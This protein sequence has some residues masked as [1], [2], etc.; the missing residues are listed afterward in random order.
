MG[1]GEG[2]RIANRSCVE[3]DEV[4]LLAPRDP[5]AIRQPDLVGRHAGHLSDRSGEIHEPPLADKVSENARVG[6]VVARVGARLA[7]RALGRDGAPVGPDH[8]EGV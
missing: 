7:R 5:A 1:I 8:D 3:D 4:G 6:P 2:G